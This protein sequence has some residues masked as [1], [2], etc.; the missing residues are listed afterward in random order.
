MIYALVTAGVIVALLCLSDMRR[1]ARIR[2]IERAER[3]RTHLSTLRHK[4]IYFAGSGE[5]EESDLEAFRWLYHANTW[6]LKYPSLYPDYSNIWV[7]SKLAPRE[8]DDRSDIVPLFSERTLPFLREYIRASDRLVNE[9]GNALL[10][11][12]AALDGKTLADWIRD[13]HERQRLIE[14]EQKRIKRLREA[15]ERALS[16][17]TGGSLAQQM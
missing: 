8:D 15:G 10:V 4:L 6:L 13:V 11:W 1:F 17:P 5:M 16:Y 14:E 7:R 3:A 9:F 12:L 2:L